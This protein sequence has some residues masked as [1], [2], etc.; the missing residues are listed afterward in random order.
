MNATDFEALPSLAETLAA[1][2]WVIYEYEV[3]RSNTVALTIVRREPERK[4]EEIVF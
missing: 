1:D 3:I 4:D 2:G